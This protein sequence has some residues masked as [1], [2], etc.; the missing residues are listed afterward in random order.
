MVDITKLS[1]VVLKIGRVLWASHVDPNV[2]SRALERGISNRGVA[3]EKSWLVP[4]RLEEGPKP[5]TTER[6]LRTTEQ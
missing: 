1:L 3:K 6:S 2:T 4:W 5:H